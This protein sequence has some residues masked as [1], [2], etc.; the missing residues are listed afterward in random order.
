MKTKLIGKIVYLKSNLSD[1]GIVLNYD[2]E[3]Y[4]VAYCGAKENTMYLSRDEFTVPRDQ[5]MLH[6]FYPNGYPV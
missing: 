3:C 2:G 1:W 4:Y 6:V 5:H